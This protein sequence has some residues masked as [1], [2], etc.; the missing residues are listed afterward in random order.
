MKITSILSG[1]YAALPRTTRPAILTA[2]FIFFAA[3]AGLAQDNPLF[4]HLPPD[5]GSIYHINIPVITAK[6]SWQDLAGLFPA[7]PGHSGQD[8]IRI[9]QDPSRA[10]I[11]IQQDLFVA[12]TEKGAPD[13]VGFTTF[14]LHLKDSAKWAAFLRQQT[15]GLRVRVHPGQIRTAS[16]D[17]M[18][19]AW[20]KDLAVI[21]EVHPTS[22]PSQTSNA[23]PRSKT[24]P[25]SSSATQ[26]TA[27][28][29]YTA[30]AL[31][32]SL[33][34][35]TGFETSFYTSDPV[36]RTGFSD[37]ADLHI[38]T[39]QGE[40]L[41]FLARQVT[42]SDPFAAIPGKRP[43][44]AKSK[45]YSLI[46][47]RFE[48]GRIILRSSAVLTPE[49]S[50]LLTKFGGR[51]LDTDLI[52][53]LPKANI[54]ALVNLHFDPSVIAGV[55]DKYKYRTKVD[56]KLTAKGLALDTLLHIFKGDFLLAAIDP[57][58]DQAASDSTPS[59]RQPSLFFV[60]TIDDLSAY[61][62][63][64]SQFGLLKDSTD[65][66]NPSAPADSS[67]NGTG[68]GDSAVHKIDWL[69]KLKSAHTLR[70]HILV[71]SDTKSRTDAF[72][73][74]T[75]KRNTDFVTEHMKDNPF[76]IWI[77]FKSVGD[78]LQHMNSKGGGP[79]EPPSEKNRQ[80][81]HIFSALDQLIISGGAI[82]NGQIET[83]IELKMTDPSENSLRSLFK[84]FH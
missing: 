27:M 35:L 84:L 40:G 63:L 10:G 20:N 82:H 49:D 53:H 68:S 78:F 57:A 9:S 30:L 52:A 6:L 3:A 45:T 83:Y 74:N 4:R 2:G 39:P 36:F 73:N 66:G 70:D 71:I 55:L 67:A 80:L 5:A 7:V 38:W 54:L 61:K 23:A 47:L 17:K 11:D 46:S 12:A 31:Q 29:R 28:A 34:A 62:K 56:S 44:A 26:A 50:D 69:S 8:M 64:T 77:D 24:L 48:P 65:T 81:L 22:H 79:Q 41:S 51:P 15:P 33:A 18:G 32:R 1:F 76:S 14:I 58:H 72:F 75:E 60:A 21:V 59:R 19:A 16:K 43:A 13:S 25:P 37:D 42:H